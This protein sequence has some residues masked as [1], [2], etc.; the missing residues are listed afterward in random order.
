MANG[1][2]V[3]HVKAGPNVY[4]VL[5]MIAALALLVSV[6]FSYYRLTASVEDGGLGMETG[7]MF[8]APAEQ[9]PVIDSGVPKTTD[10]DQP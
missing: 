3:V 4:T 9:K 8:K 2:N 10:L 6:G 1:G 7:D 5:I